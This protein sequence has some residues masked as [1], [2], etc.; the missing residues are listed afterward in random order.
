[1]KLLEKE[2]IWKR[3]IRKGAFNYRLN[4]PFRYD[5]NKNY[6]KLLTQADL[7][8]IIIKNHKA[9]AREKDGITDSIL[10]KRQY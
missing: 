7:T 8:N 4:V 10:I 9:E 3:L 2:D 1:M 6:L 5:K